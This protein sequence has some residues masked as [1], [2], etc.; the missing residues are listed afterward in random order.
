MCM[1][2]E[3][4]IRRMGDR[5]LLVEIGEGIDP[6]VNGRVH[7]LHRALSMQPLAGIHETVPGYC[8]LMVVFDPLALTEQEITAWIERVL[9]VSEGIPPAEARHLRIPVCYGGPYGPDLE[10]VAGFH[11]ISPEEV[12]RIHTSVLYMVYLIGFTPG[13]SYLGE[14]PEA[15]DTPRKETPRTRVPTGSVGIAQRQTGIY[16]AESPGGWQIIGRTPLRMFDPSRWPPTLLEAG[17]RVEFFDVPPEEVRE[18]DVWPS[19]KS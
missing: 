16:P 8:S 11:A 10:W 3:P 18:W 2:S 13:F 12:V 7:A 5:A 15:L 6:M 14:L 19:W 17:D 9:S 1:Y 4:V